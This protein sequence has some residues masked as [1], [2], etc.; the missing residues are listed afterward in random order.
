MQYGIYQQFQIYVNLLIKSYRESF[1]KASSK[2][3]C[4]SKSDFESEKASEIIFN[5]QLIE[6]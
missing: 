6:L 1:R 5:I 3:M 2:K 4:R